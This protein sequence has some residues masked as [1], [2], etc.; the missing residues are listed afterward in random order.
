VRRRA[1]RLIRYLVPSAMLTGLAIRQLLIGLWRCHGIPLVL[2]VMM[3]ILG[4]ATAR[5]HDQ[6]ATK[7]PSSIIGV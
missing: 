6:S 1:E 5:P 4:N 2:P 3:P 7:L